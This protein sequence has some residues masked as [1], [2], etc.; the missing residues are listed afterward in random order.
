MRSCGHEFAGGEDGNL[1]HVLL[2]FFILVC[3]M[4]AKAGIYVENSSSLYL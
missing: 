1:V 2:F 4:T 3:L